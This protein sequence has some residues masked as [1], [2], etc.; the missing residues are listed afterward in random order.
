MLDHTRAAAS[1]SLA[2][3]DN[4]FVVLASC[5][6]FA[7]DDGMR[8]SKPSSHRRSYLVLGIILMFA[9]PLVACTIEIPPAP[10]NPR[11]GKE[12]RILFSSGCASSVTMPVGA[13]E[14]IT[15]QS[16]EE[17]G[18]LPSDLIP[19]SVDSTI[20]EVLQPSATSF[21]MHAL[22]KGQTDIEVS[23]AGA[24]FDSITFQVEPAKVVKFASEGSVLAGG[25]TGLAIT[26]IFGACGTDECG[27]FGHTFVKWSADPAGSFTFLEDTK[28]LAHYRAS[29]TPGQGALIG[30]EPSE[31]GEL[32]RQNV[33]IVDPA[34]IT[35]LSGTLTNAS[36]SNNEDPKP[37][38]F[39]AVVTQSEFFEVRL[40]GDR[41]GKSAVPISWHDIEWTAPQ[42]LTVLAQSEPT[43]PFASS[44]IASDMTGDFT[45]TAKVA[46]LGG[47]E[48]AFVVTVKA[49]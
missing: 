4:E 13:T 16:P 41:A 18:V 15:M 26:D 46:L 27:L 43:D 40:F 36:T 21:D 37:V 12:K 48:Q 32:V 10:P 8:K 20:I 29:T 28:N 39:P 49:P 42:G 47:K 3:A 35:T 30:N 25:R 44:F 17:N 7:T 5:T 1:W 23:S 2:P 33:E 24:R 6:R 34:T 22:K 45:I 14:T 11:L 19:K 31:G 38:P 9:A